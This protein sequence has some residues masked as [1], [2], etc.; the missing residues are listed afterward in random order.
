MQNKHFLITHKNEDR[1]IFIDKVKY[2][3]TIFHVGDNPQEGDIIKDPLKG[4]HTFFSE[5]VLENYNNLP[6]YVVVCQAIPGDHVHEPLLAIDATFTS[7]FGSLCY[8][9]SLYNQYSTN[10]GHGF[11]MP[12]RTLLH[13]LGLGFINDNNVEKSL[14]MVYPGEINFVSRKRIL[15]KPKSFYEKL[16][17]LDSNKAIYNIIDNQEFPRFFYE[18]IKRNFP[19]YKNHSNKQLLEIFTDKTKVNEKYGLLGLCLESLWMIIFAGREQFKTLEK[20]QAVI[21]NKLY[22]DI[23]KSS[24]D[25]NFNFN[26]FPYNNDPN[27]TKINLKLMEND[28]F[29]WNCPYYLKWRKTLVEKTIWEG[30]QRGFDGKQLLEFYE[31]VGYKHISL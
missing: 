18:D 20:S 2:S 31:R 8:A 16:S 13:E 7:D 26:I 30:E 29:K 28:W 15:E 12:L 11:S 9:R 19:Q 21:G 22:C 5:W 24:Y 6:D 25:A 23:K 1:S 14:Y 4:F 10:W 17:S 3:K 27:V